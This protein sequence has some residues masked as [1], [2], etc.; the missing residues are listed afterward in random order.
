MGFRDK[1]AQSGVLGR[2]MVGS[3]GGIQQGNPGAPEVSPEAPG[4]VEMST[5]RGLNQARGSR[6]KEEG[7]D[8][9]F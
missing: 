3:G 2:L 1:L 8:R 5:Q 6:D 9:R 4:V 7:L